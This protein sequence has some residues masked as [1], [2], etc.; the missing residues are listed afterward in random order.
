MML[1]TSSHNGAPE[2]LAEDGAV[3]M[4]DMEKGFSSWCRWN[5]NEHRWRMQMGYS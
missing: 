4:N 5:T 3:Y 2:E 1:V